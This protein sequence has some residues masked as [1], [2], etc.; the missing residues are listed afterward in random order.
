MIATDTTAKSLDALITWHL[1]QINGYGIPDVRHCPGK[2]LN[3]QFNI[4]INFV[5]SLLII[6]A[7]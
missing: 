5:S 3:L 6:A 2:W 1:C 7:A 4:S